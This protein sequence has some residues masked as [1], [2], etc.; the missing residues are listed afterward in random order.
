MELLTELCDIQGVSGDE[1]NVR[2][3]ILKYL[4]PLEPFVDK[5][6]NIYLYIPTTNPSKTL[7]IA[8]HMDEVGFIVSHIDKNTGRIYLRPLGGT[9][10]IGSIGEE[11]RIGKIYGI[12]TTECVSNFTNKEDKDIYVDT[13][14][15]YDELDIEIGSFVNFTRKAK[16][17]DSGLIVGKAIDDRFA[18]YI[19][20]DLINSLRSGK[21]TSPNN[22]LFL[23][24]VREELLQQ[25]ILTDIEYW[26]VDI[27]IAL[28]T[29]NSHEYL[30]STKHNTRH[31]GDGPIIVIYNEAGLTYTPLNNH[32]KAIAK[33]NNIPI[34]LT[35]QSEGDTDV[36]RVQII[37][38]NPLPAT[39][40]SIAVKNVHTAFSIASLKDISNLSKLLHIIISGN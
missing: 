25:G 36:H 30:T 39:I 16:I 19:M 29:V 6:G 4:H 17:L 34:Q 11:V 3:F 7:L 38:K 33:Q 5:L 1:A 20:L 31:V 8:S 24:S 12:I 22:L 15:S 23:F 2:N 10:I 18:C 35:L 32:I 9:Q 13:G 14:Y 40:L 27:I 26:K 28:D 37:T 21:I